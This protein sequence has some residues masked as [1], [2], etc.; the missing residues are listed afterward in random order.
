MSER[1]MSEYRKYHII[2]EG[3]LETNMTIQEIK[4]ET[5]VT[6]AHWG[7][8]RQRVQVKRIVNK[9]VKAKTP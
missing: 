6:V 8:D 3:D 7:L 4:E 2:I 9:Q 1:N 5:R